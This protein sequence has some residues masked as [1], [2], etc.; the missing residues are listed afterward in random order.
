MADAKTYSLKEI[1][2]NLIN[3]TQQQW[4]VA[5]SNILSFIALERLAYNVTENTQF[6]IEGTNLIISEKEA[7]PEPEQPESPIAQAAKGDK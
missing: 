6:T 1:E 4:Q 3:L 7:A 2:I 5:V